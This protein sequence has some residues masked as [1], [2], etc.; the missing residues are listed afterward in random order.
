MN[1][2]KLNH[3]CQLNIGEHNIKDKVERAVKSIQRKEDIAINRS[4]LK[5]LSQNAVIPAHFQVSYGDNSGGIHTATPPGVL[6]VLC[7]N[8]LFKYLLRNL[9]DSIEIPLRFKEY[10]KVVSKVG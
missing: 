2:D 6:H 3:R 8:G 10:W 1:S 9:F 5:N 4:I 7:E